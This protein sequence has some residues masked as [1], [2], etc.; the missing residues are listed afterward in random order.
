LLLDVSSLPADEISARSLIEVTLLPT[1]IPWNFFSPL[2]C[3]G[4][5]FSLTMESP[6]S[7]SPSPHFG[8]TGEHGLGEVR[9]LYFLHQ[10]LLLFFSLS[11]TPASRFLNFPDKGGQAFSVFSSQFFFKRTTA[12]LFFLV[13]AGQVLMSVEQAFFFFL[14]FFVA[15]RFFSLPGRSPPPSSLT[16]Q[17]LIVTGAFFLHPM[18][19]RN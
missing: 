13:F 4:G 7:A 11:G 6:L 8:L 10:F 18:V 9:L 16:L 12:S 5:P 15:K 14:S 1:G 2:T 3:E 17:A 19:T